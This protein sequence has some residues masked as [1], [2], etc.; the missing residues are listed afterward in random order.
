MTIYGEHCFDF[1]RFGVNQLRTWTPAVL[2]FYISV[3]GQEN[4]DYPT[5]KL[6]GTK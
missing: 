3:V 6:L 4:N 5:Y 1:N 2:S